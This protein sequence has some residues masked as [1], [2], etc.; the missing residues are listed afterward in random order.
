MLNI[1]PTFE[2][3]STSFGSSLLVKKHTEAETRKKKNATWW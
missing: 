3:V 2:K 1:K